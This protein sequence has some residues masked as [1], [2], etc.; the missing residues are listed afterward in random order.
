MAEDFEE[1]FELKV[2]ATDTAEYPDASVLLREQKIPFSKKPV[3]LI[4]IAIAV[5]I[6]AVALYKVTDTVIFAQQRTEEAVANNVARDVSYDFI[7]LK[8]FV[9]Y[10]DS[11]LE[12]YLE[13]KFDIYKVQPDENFPSGG[14]DLFKLPSD[15]S[16]SEATTMLQDG[17]AGMSAENASK[18]F[19]GGYRVSMDLSSYFDL[20]IRYADFKSGSLD[21]AISNALNEQGFTTSETEI[22]DSGVDESGNTYKAG[23]IEIGEKT[24]FWRI[25][26]VMLDDVYSIKNMPEKGVYV[27]VRITN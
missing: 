24:Y 14:F 9:D 3:A 22:T 5:V 19:T 25:S 15:V 26:A 20:K 2:V 1:P 13:S 8:D 16:V 6:A 10:S 21:V 18:L 11:E 23:T 12:S 27:G 17:F 4:I 7:H